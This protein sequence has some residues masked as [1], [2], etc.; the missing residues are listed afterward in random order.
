MGQWPTPAN[1]TNFLATARNN[2]LPAAVNGILFAN[3][4]FAKYGVVPT[5]QLLDNPNSALTAE[6]FLNRLHISAG[7]RPP[8]PLDRVTFRSNNVLSATRGRGYSV[9]GLPQA[10]TEFVTN[11]NSTNT[12]LFA[13]ARAAALFY[14][15]ARPPI[16][17]TVDEI[18][19]RIDAL[20]KLPN[21]TAIADAV[22]KD[23]LY[24][25]RYVTI[26]KQPQSL[27]VAPRSG[28]IFTVEAQ[29]APPLAYQWLFNG[30]PI[31]GATTPTLSLTNVD[32]GRVGSYKVAI[33]SP[34]ATDTSDVATLTL[35]TTPTRLANISTRGQTT[36]GANVLIGGF[37]VSGANQTQTRQMLIRVIGPTLAAAPFN[38]QGALA[39]PRLELYAANA[40]TPALQNDNWANQQG[41]AQQVTAIQ[42]AMT[43]AGA[44]T[45]NQNSLDA[46]VLA[47]L[48]PGSYTV[49]AK[50]PANNPNATGVVLIE[51]YDVTPNAAAPGKAMNVSTRGTVGTGT[52][53]LIAGFVVDGAVSRRVLIRGVGPTLTRFGLAA[54]TVLADPRLTLIN[55]NTGATIATNDDW[56]V[57]D[58][59]GVIAAAASAA[60]A[61]ALNNGSKDA[62]MIV[63][64]APGNYTVQLAGVNNGTGIAIVEVYDVDP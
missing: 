24:G 26:T 28:A 4:Y 9:V 47:T 23:V 49:Q 63:M 21:T 60:G 13:R 35:S 52:N 45:L 7:I 30:A 17:V 61:F 19:A 51:A 31:P 44:F 34:A 57:T 18:T 6:E 10:I 43:R 16:T 20:L 39:D 42:Q 11:T 8:E 33:T 55:Q 36:G 14:Q 2:G 46:V 53:I 58:D 12:A 54:N 40:A 29:G 62:A 56:A 64:L 59:A 48:P 38:V 27:V 25:Y 50:G 3:E 22:L 15:L 37:V 32:V 5:T 41:G 1:Y